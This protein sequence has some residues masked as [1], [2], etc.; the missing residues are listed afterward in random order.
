M[1]PE[2]LMLNQYFQSQS[3]LSIQTIDKDDKNVAS[4]VIYVIYCPQ[5]YK[6]YRLDFPHITPLMIHKGLMLQH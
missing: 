2:A 3:M 4:L 6:N 5:S 1:C